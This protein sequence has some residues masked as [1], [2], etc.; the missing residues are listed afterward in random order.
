MLGLSTTSPVGSIVVGSIVTTQNPS[1]ATAR[2]RIRAIASE[3]SRTGARAAPLTG[4]A[5]PAELRVSRCDCGIY[6]PG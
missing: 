3:K 2:A 5:D 1:N 4:A 6:T